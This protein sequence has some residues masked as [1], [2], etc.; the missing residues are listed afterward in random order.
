VPVFVPQVIRGGGS[1]VCAE[2]VEILQVRCGVVWCGVV[3]CGVVW[4][5]VVLCCDVWCNILLILFM[6][7]NLG[8]YSSRNAF[9]YTTLFYIHHSL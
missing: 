6:C 1:K 3:W 8:H 9:L 4:C 7:S 2:G 5:G